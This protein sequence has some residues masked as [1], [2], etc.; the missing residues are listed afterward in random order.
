MRGTRHLAAIQQ[1]EVL[2]DRV[3]FYEANGEGKTKVSVNKWLKKGTLPD[4]YPVRFM[5]FDGSLYYW[6]SDKNFRLAL[7]NSNYPDQPIATYTAPNGRTSS[8]VLIANV[9][10]REMLLN[11]APEV[12]SAFILLE[13]KMRRG[14]CQNDP[15][16]GGGFGLELQ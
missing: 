6:K 3:A 2:P 7:Y 4:K 10:E 12:L 13:G 14:E 15:K 1:N 16:G 8:P 5:T 9:S 11:H